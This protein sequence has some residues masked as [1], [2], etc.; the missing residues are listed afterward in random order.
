MASK[1]CQECGAPA[2]DGVH[3]AGQ[4]GDEAGVQVAGVPALREVVV[5]REGVLI[6]LAVAGGIVGGVAL[7]VGLLMLGPI[8]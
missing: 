6:A 3:G 2:Q 4:D 7:G 8:L 1:T 5:T